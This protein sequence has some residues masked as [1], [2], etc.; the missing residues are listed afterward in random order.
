MEAIDLLSTCSETNNP[1][2][3]RQV[4]AIAYAIAPSLVF[5]AAT[6]PPNLPDHL[7][8]ALIAKAAQQ[9]DAAVQ[10]GFA[11]P[12]NEQLI[13]GKTPQERDKERDDE[14]ISYA[15]LVR[16]ELDEIRKREEASYQEWRQTRQTYAGQTMN[17]EDWHR[18]MNWFRDP[19]NAA[20]WENAMMAKTGQSREEVRETGGKMKRFYDLVEK[21]ARGRMSQDERSEF[22]KLNA[23]KDVKRGV[24]VQQ[25]IQ[26]LQR[27]RSLEVSGA[28]E[29]NF[30][31]ANQERTTSF[32]STFSDEATLSSSNSIPALS[33]LY[34][35]AA[36]G[37]P[38]TS[39]P[40]PSALP[41][42]P[43]AQTVQVSPDNMFG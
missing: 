35:E 33:S 42:L 16:E 12:S 41:G 25:E 21:D 31:G 7:Q 3:E 23:D 26:G 9:R 14:A 27:S 40:D 11:M 34:K 13:D 22:D 43:P 18:M 10:A 5:N 24:E 28:S 30:N 6:L 1:D 20:D 17:G 39:P 8:A 19:A 29:A 38:K 2:T 37:K 15:A 4:D 36:N 32:A